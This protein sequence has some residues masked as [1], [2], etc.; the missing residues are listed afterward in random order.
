M[1]TD[2]SDISVIIQGRLDEK[3]I[4][5]CI[6][7]INNNLPHSEII[8]STWNDH[9]FLISTNLLPK[10][11]KIVK[12]V[13]PGPTDF[14]KFFNKTEWKNNCCNTNRQIVSTR[15]GL[16]HA[17]RKYALKLRGDTILLNS[18]LLST[19]SKYSNLN[20]NNY[21]FKERL[22][23]GGALKSSLQPFYISDMYMFGLTTDIL[24]L[25]SIPLQPNLVEIKDLSF[26]EYNSI[27]MISPEQYL[28]SNLV[29][30]KRFSPFNSRYDVRPINLNLSDDLIFNSLIPTY[31]EQSG[32]V[33]MKYPG[34]T[35][36]ACNSS[37][38]LKFYDWA[39]FN[40][41]I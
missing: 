35:E 22:L 27:F 5:K 15:N 25:F 29:K 34:I 37:D 36:E 24:D 39:V 38:A 17:S 40:K 32:I 20:K 21:F 23:T 9:H 18:S 6:L 41:S 28:W 1:I 4:N 7:S 26:E 11:N 8:I 13:D 31:Y 33:N 12:S 16:S 14:Y 30:K 3:F 10:I 19:Y 2:S